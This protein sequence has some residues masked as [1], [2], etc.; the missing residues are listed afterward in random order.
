MTLA[1]V[2]TIIGSLIIGWFM[3]AV[4]VC[5]FLTSAI[6][7]GHLKLLD[8]GKWIDNTNWK[9]WIHESEQVK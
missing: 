4:C 9:Q 5:A 7:N 2:L 8:K 6:R 1:Y 3:G